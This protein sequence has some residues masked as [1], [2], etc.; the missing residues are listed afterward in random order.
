[1]QAMA[2]SFCKNTLQG[3]YETDSSAKRILPMEGLRGLAILLVF[4]CHFQIVILERL[5]NTF[6]SKF[7]LVVAQLGG[8]GVDLFFLLS[9][10]L[11]YRAAMRPNLHYGKFLLRRIQRIY[12]TFIV[13]LALYILLSI[14]FHVG[15]HY[16]ATGLKSQTA[17]LLEN[18]FL[19]PGVVDIPPIISAAWSL[20]YEFAFY[21]AVPLLVRA[22]LLRR[23]YPS[24]RASF[25]V[26]VIFSYLG[27][28]LLEPGLL[29]QYQYQDGSFVRFTLFL[30][31]MVVEEILT[32][33]RG[34]RL[35]APKIQWCLL[36]SGVTAAAALFL[37]E[38]HTV[39]TPGHERAEHAVVRAFLV[40]VVYVGLA[41]N[42]L[43]VHGLFAGFFSM[44]VVRWTGNISYSFYLIHGFM[45]NVLA[46]L[47]G[48][49]AWVNHRGSIAVPLLFALAAVS[50]FA[51]ATV[52]FL[53]VEKPYSL[54]PGANRR[55]S[56]MPMRA[57]A[58]AG[59]PQEI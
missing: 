37:S 27:F 26:V 53:T 58:L 59:K 19:L 52:L 29:P 21:L 48:H 46:V 8:T 6:H 44:T 54:R 5:A 7:Y 47:V 1:M 20:S 39:G 34:R 38:W 3:W 24:G 51:A 57:E 41:L 50:T 4:I 55:F 42:A 30:A 12:P 11:I 13:V 9:G 49:L 14:F 43:N 35:L 25:C 18:V 56:T 23:W 17:Y 28:A 10:M 36:L 33:Q 22:L 40:L 31:G 16:H 15:E 45:L 32:S 2:M